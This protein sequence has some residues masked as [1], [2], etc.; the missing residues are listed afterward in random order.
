MKIV[1]RVGQLSSADGQTEVSV[2]VGETD[3]ELRTK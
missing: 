3:Y 1:K 2:V